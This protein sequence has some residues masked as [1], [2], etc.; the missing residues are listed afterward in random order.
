MK[1]Q[2]LNLEE[3]KTDDCDLGIEM[4]MLS[5]TRKFG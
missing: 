2:I 4:L 3:K 1:D 5:E